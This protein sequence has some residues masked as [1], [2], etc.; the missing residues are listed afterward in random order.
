MGV[1]VRL[2]EILQAMEMP[3]EWESFLDPETGEI[4]TISE[5]GRIVLDR[6]EDGEAVDVPAW[7]GESTARIRRVLDSGRALAL[8]DS[9]DVHEWDLMRRFANSVEYADARDEILRAIHGTGAFRLFRMTVD[10]LGLR[11]AWFRYRDDSMR[12]LARAWLEEHG[13]AYVEEVR[14]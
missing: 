2:D 5:D 13:I 6:E 8:P 1:A 9:F 14:G 10:R 12:D 3:P 4:V 7:Q 11:D